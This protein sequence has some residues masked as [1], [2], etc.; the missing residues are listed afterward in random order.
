MPFS[1]VERAIEDI[2]AGK[3]VL[4]ADD[5][6]QENEGDLIC[7]AELITPEKVNFMLEAKGWICLALTPERCEQLQLRPMTR[8]NTAAMKTAFTVTIDASGR[9]GETTA[10]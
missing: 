6:D 4:V 3:F 9:F 2:R 8:A 10:I 7:A 1:T 5:E